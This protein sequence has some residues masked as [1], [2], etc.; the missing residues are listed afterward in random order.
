MA[1]LS[2]GFSFRSVF[3]HCRRWFAGCGGAAASATETLECQQPG[4]GRN[5]TLALAPSPRY[6]LLS[7]NSRGGR[8]RTR[9]E[10]E[11]AARTPA[12]PRRHGGE[13]TP[14]TGLSRLPTGGTRTPCPPECGSPGSAHKRRD[15]LT[16]R[17][18][19]VTR[20]HADSA[21]RRVSTGRLSPAV[22]FPRSLEP[23]QAR[24]RT[25][26]QGW[27]SRAGSRSRDSR[28]G[29]PATRPILLSASERQTQRCRERLLGRGRPAAG[30]ADRRTAVC[31]RLA[32]AKDLASCP[33]ASVLPF[34]CPSARP[35]ESVRPSIPQSLRPVL[36]PTLRPYLPTY[37]DVHAYA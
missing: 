17:A 9:S 8:T 31:C 37:L 34:P 35:S 22:E 21:H 4:T 36:H 27:P 24:T 14:T 2:A 3:C 7:N 16:R 11:G 10:P 13:A 25:Q 32:E 18:R 19:A 15:L 26:R 20:T 30:P 5:S 28:P 23:L 1:V 33:L 12:S 29:D 6:S